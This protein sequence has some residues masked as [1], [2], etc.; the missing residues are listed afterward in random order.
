[1]YSI[2][3]N[4]G[5]V[6][7][8]RAARQ[9]SVDTIVSDQPDPIAPQ[10][11]WRLPLLLAV[12]AIA[13]RVILILL[14]PDVR[15]D[16][17]I[18][19][20]YGRMMAQ[21]LNPY[22]PPADGAVSPHYANIAPFNLALFA[23]VFR[24]WDTPTAL[25]LLFALVDGVIILVL[26]YALRRNRSWRKGVMLYYAFNPL[27]LT[28]LVID[29]E[30]KV[31]VILMTLI[32]VA[33]VEAHRSTAS[34]LWTTALTLYRWLG[35]FFVLPLTFYFART[36][37][38]L[39]AMLGLYG[40]AFA[41]SHVAYWPA[42]LFIYQSRAQRT[43]INPPIHDSPTMLLAALGLYTPRLVTLFI[44]LT[45]VVLYTLFLLRRVTLVEVIILS[46]FFTT[47]AS[48]ELPTGRIIMVSVPLF[49][50]LTLPRRR[51]VPLWVVTAIAAPFLYPDLQARLMG[52]LGLPILIPYGSLPHMLLMNLLPALLLV[53]YFI[54]KRRGVVP[55]NTLLS[56]GWLLER[57]WHNSPPQPGAPAGPVQ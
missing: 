1:M 40:I 33:S 18:Y 56:H 31:V 9:Q 6:L 50:L 15:D 28:A 34:L 26:G 39:I 8:A 23:A 44:L 14:F 29:A 42:N 3:Q 48:P 51:L 45:L 17:R 10:P 19:T 38:S 21:G 53:Y 35:A 52:M 49:L 13:L 2:V 32:I 4:D 20:Y 27:V 57:L 36:W 12:L 41:L 30:D 22:L 7:C 46:A 5:S 24:L 55:S 16:L 54:D 43:L 47:M 25:R 11:L 37:R